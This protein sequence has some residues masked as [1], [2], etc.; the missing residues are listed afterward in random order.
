MRL[1]AA[2]ETLGRNRECQ[3]AL[4]EALTCLMLCKLAA[5]QIQLSKTLPLQSNKLPLLL[6][7]GVD[8]DQYME[9]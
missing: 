3:L 6:L 2:G 1:T 8:T 5:W 9:E 7:A 4:L